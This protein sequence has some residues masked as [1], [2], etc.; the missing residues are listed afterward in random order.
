MSCPGTLL[1]TEQP[2]MRVPEGP[3]LRPQG[4]QAETSFTSVPGTHPLLPPSLSLFY[5]LFLVKIIT[6]VR[7]GV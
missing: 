3:M 2:W 6:L 7:A 1:G 4:Q 5:S